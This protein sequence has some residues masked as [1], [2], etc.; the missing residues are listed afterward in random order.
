MAAPSQFAK[1]LDCVYCGKKNAASRWPVHGDM[2]P[3]YAQKEPGKYQVTVRC[4]HCHRDWYVVW[5]DNPGA[6]CDTGTPRQSGAAPVS[7]PLISKPERR[8]E[9][10]PTPTRNAATEPGKQI[11]QPCK[12]VPNSI[13]RRILGFFRRNRDPDQLIGELIAIGRPVKDASR[14]RS[15]YLYFANKSGESVVRNARA[16]RIGW[17]LH[18]VGGFKLMLAAHARVKEALG[19]GAARDL[20]SCWGDVGEWQS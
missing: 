4:P 10:I 1:D 18:K 16:R 17:W 8:K 3:F 15:G 9:G 6:G 13:L 2:V 14:E 12:D 11:P 7:Q 5:D 19:P 20:E